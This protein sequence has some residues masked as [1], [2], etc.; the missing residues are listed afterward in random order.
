MDRRVRDEIEEGC[1]NTFSIDADQIAKARMVLGFEPYGPFP[2]DEEEGLET[3]FRAVMHEVFDKAIETFVRSPKRARLL[4][5]WEKTWSQLIAVVADTGGF[6]RF[7]SNDVERTRFGDRIRE[8]RDEWA[9][10]EADVVRPLAL[11]ELDRL[12]QTEYRLR[13]R[14]SKGS[15]ARA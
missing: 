9:R 11:T 14:L 4:F 2:D 1:R 13:G 8:V 3:A 15:R 12:L 5:E 6:K 10:K 7:S